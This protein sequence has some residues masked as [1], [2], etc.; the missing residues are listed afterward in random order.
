MKTIMFAAALFSFAMSTQAEAGPELPKEVTTLLRLNGEWSSQNGTANMAGKQSKVEIN[1]SCAPTP[2]KIGLLCQSRITVEGL[3]TMEGTDLF[4]FDPAS[5][6]FHWFCVNGMGDVH[7]HVAKIP[8]PKDK[9]FTWVFE[10]PGKDGKKVKE[11][12][13]MNLDDA[14]TKMEFRN[15]FTTGGQPFMKMAATLTKK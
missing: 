12:I 5:K 15:D 3:G 1:V 10:G 11:V 7:D 14:G 8:G 9:G 4:G 2:N 6:S 13:A